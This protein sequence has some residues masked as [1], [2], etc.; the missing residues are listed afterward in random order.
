MC[1]YHNIWQFFLHVEECE[2]AIEVCKEFNLPIAAMITIGPL[3]DF[4]DV[5]PGDC[6]VRMSRAGA[7]VVGT[8]CYFDPSTALQTIALMKEGLIEAGLLDK[9]TYLMAQP[10]GFHCP[11]ATTKLGYCF[12]A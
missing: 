4:N 6:A 2:W 12:L 10:V 3:G 9:P 11:D 5:S 7:D 8:N 1:S